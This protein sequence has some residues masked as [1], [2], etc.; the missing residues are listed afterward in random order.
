[1][2]PVIRGAA[3]RSVSIASVWTGSGRAADCPVGCRGTAFPATTPA[4]R[5]PVWRQCPQ[6]ACS[7]A[8][9][10]SSSSRGYEEAIRTQDPSDP[11]PSTGP[12]PFR[13][14]A[15]FP[16]PQSALLPSPPAPQGAA[17]RLAHRPATPRFQARRPRPGAFS[18]EHSG[19]RHRGRGGDFSSA[20]TSARVTSQQPQTQVWSLRGAAAEPLWPSEGP[21]QGSRWLGA[22]YR[23]AASPDSG[24]CAQ[25]PPALV[26]RAIRAPRAAGRPAQAPRTAPRGSGSSSGWQSSSWNRGSSS[27]AAAEQPAV[28]RS[29]GAGR[30]GR[31]GAWG[32]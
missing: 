32:R 1:M 14:S 24:P 23:R 17:R 3:A 4:R 22:D 26:A 13:S 12:A 10:Q 20:P 16:L 9:W 28:C 21:H 6:L 11:G 19:A 31:S 25:R 30:G 2:G 7:P 5:G 8:C 27:H 18:L 29:I 15:R